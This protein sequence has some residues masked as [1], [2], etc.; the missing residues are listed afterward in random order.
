MTAKGPYSLGGRAV[1]MGK[2]PEDR[3]ISKDPAS[4]ERR[5]AFLLFSSL[6]RSRK[7]QAQ[8]ERVGTQSRY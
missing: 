4:L 2:C 5:G 8:W 6:V 3:T 7:R 1:M